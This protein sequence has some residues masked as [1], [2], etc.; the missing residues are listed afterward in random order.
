MTSKSSSFGA[1]HLLALDDLAHRE[2]LVPHP[3]RALEL[4]RFGRLVHLLLEPVEDRRGV[5]VEERD[6]L[7]RRAAS[8]SSWSIAPTHGAAHF[9]MC[10]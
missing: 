3:R 8:Y 1:D 5:A 4:E 6:Q 10:A 7:L 2:Q 9:S